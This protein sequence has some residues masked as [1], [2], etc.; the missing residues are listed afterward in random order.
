M[1]NNLKMPRKAIAKIHWLSAAE[2]GRQ[3][4]PSGPRYSTLARFEKESTKWPEVAWS[5][6]ADFKN[7]LDSSSI[8]AEIN[9]LS[10]DAPLHLLECGNRF[11]LYEG[12]RLVA[13]GEVLKER[14]EQPPK[15][16]RIHAN[17]ELQAQ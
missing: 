3:Y 4:P 2:G 14:V 9:F 11:E 8:E 17:A 16:T 12:H 1:K 5:I 13:H 7:Q 10:P 6:V 15:I